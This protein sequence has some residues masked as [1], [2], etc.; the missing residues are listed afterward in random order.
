M[1]GHVL[2]VFLW[3]LAQVET[4]GDASAVGALGER[5]LWQMRPEVRRMYP[6]AWSE[7]EAVVA[8]VARIE[9]KLS[10]RGIAPTVRNVAAAWNAGWPAVARGRVPARAWDHARRVEALFNER[11]TMNKTENRPPA[12]LP[13]SAVV[14]LLG[15]EHVRLIRALDNELMEFG[16]DR[17]WRCGQTFYTVD[18]LRVL[19]RGLGQRGRTDLE[20]KLRAKLEEE[21][22]AQ[23]PWYQRGAYA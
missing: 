4:G 19:A 16:R 14:R 20:N 7:R 8:H 12:G 3:A 9:R 18:G 15:R 6:A 5:G 13:E 1:S 11:I 10:E 21:E 17:L 23:L 22:E 2:A